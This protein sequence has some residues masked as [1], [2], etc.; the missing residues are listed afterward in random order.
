MDFFFHILF[1]LALL[2]GD[3]TSSFGYYHNKPK[4]QTLAKDLTKF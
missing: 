4:K 2:E 3:F 1:L